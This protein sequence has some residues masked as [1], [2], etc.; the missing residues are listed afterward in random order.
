M[1][2][3][4]RQAV[5]V[6]GM[7][8]SGTSA[9]TGALA[10]LGFKLPRTP[11]PDAA[12]NPEG[13][14]ESHRIVQRNFEILRAENCFWNVCFTLEPA[15]LLAKTPPETIEQLAGILDHEFGGAEDFVLKD[16]R[17]CL[18]LPLWFPGLLRLAPRP[19]VLLMLRHPAEVMRSLAA[20]NNLSEEEVLLN[21][22]HHMLEAERMTRELPRALLQ[23]DALLQDWRTALGAALRR[24]EIT[25]P[26]AF[27]AA[28]GEIDAFIAPAMRHHAAHEAG[29]RI[30]PAYLAPLVDTSWRA[31]CALARA[32]QD[33]YALAALD[34]ALDNFRLTRQE[35]IRSGLHVIVPPGI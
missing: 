15:V 10:R 23:L 13:F 24:A 8:R 11:L 7:H 21:W 5:I 16:P 2:T 14:Y 27:E 3:R 9:L 18:L 34:D 33:G 17:L 28:G 25:P 22:L 35:L 31:L 4:P 20:R 1:S 12:D 6:L 32:P 29:A 19:G 30:G 26:R